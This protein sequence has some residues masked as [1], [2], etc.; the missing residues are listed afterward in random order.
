M[1]I[2]DFTRIFNDFEHITG[3]PLE[4]E[5]VMTYCSNCGSANVDIPVATLKD[6]TTFGDGER[7]TTTDALQVQIKY[8]ESEQQ[9]RMMKDTMMCGGKDVLGYDS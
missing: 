7:L 8:C 1:K 5:S 4:I 2:N 9:K 6:G 3:Y